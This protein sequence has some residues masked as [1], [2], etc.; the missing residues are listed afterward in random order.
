MS[1]GQ[2]LASLSSLT[3]FKKTLAVAVAVG[4]ATA[5]S[6]LWAE[7]DLQGRLTSAS[8]DIALSGAL[9]SIPELGRSTQTKRDGSF[10]FSQLPSGSYQ[11]QLNYLGGEKIE[12]KVDIRDDETTQ[13]KLSLKPADSELENILVIGNAAS[14]NTALN[15]QRSADSI[16][17][18]VKSDGIGQ[19]PDANTS[20]AL[21]RLPGISVEN[22]QGEGRFVRV[23]GL[24]P[25]FNS[26]TINGS[27]VPSPNAGNRAVA[28]DVIPSDIIESLEVYK[29]L[30]PDL[31]ADSLGGTVEV[32]SLS[33]FDRENG[34]YKLSV[35]NHYDS[36]TSQ[37]SPKFSLTGSHQL[38]LGSSDKNLGIAGSLSWFEREFGSDNVETGGAWSGDELGEFE[39]RDYQ[40]TRER[41]GFVLNF[42]FKASD[43]TQL[44][45]RT[46]STEYSDTEIRQAN[47]FE[48]SDDIASG[49]LAPAAQDEIV[50]GS[51]ELIQEEIEPSVIE[52]E[53][54]DRKETAKI[55]SLVLGG[56]TDLGLWKLDY[57]LG[58]SESS[59][60]TP[61]YID[62]AVFVRE[63]D[64]GLGFEGSKIIHPLAPEG[65]LQASEYGDFEVEL[66]EQITRDKEQNFKFNAERLFQMGKR[67]AS[68]KFGFKLSQREKDSDETVWAM[69]DEDLSLADFSDANANV[70][71]EFGEMGPVILSQQILDW[72]N[73]QNFADAR[74]DIDSI[75]NDFVINEDINASYLMGT[76]TVDKW[77][78][79]Y[80]LRYEATSTEAR[81]H[82]VRVVEVDDEEQEIF[83]L[84]QIDNDYSHLLPS[85]HLR[86]QLDDKTQLRAAITH[87]VV[88]PSF[89]QISPY[90]SQDGDEA[91]FGNPELEPL[92]SRNFDLGIEHYRGYAS[93]YSAFVFYKQIEDFI[94][95]IDLGENAG[96]EGV[97][98]A[99]T[100]RN[101]DT[102]TIKGLE[103]A[104]SQHFSDL[105]A[106][107]NGLFVS[108][109]ATWS[110]SEAQLGYYDDEVLLSRSL[111]MPSQ[112]DL[113]ANFAIGWESDR[114]SVRLAT[115][116]KSEYLLEVQSPDA[117]EEDI[118]VDEQQSVD[119]LGRWYVNEKLQVFI[120]G[121][122][123]SDEPYYTYVNRKRFNAQYEDYGPSYRLG[124]SLSH[125]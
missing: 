92:S 27:K 47:V 69:D 56:E 109:N 51:G 62:G 42:D 2:A 20:E 87:S 84:T 81:G 41:L 65:Y 53:L 66:A 117:A 101:G 19:Y 76:Y 38:A 95:G 4:A 93:A 58:S 97:E 82:S 52:R 10:S 5:S 120:Q 105:P 80:G 116:Y 123:L 83:A 23:R 102:A 6:Q 29:T 7:G 16:L 99:F 104:G 118:Y 33:A 55:S 1:T 21:Q 36:K 103:L 112:S 15:Q 30:T 90:Y 46:L 124:F 122:N 28:L 79:I 35:E 115:N 86:Y 14:I 60:D 9:V 13:I 85:F 26:V 54:K 3:F 31:D 89:E 67:S 108:A 43:N 24:G 107:W 98:E 18:V 8:G 113:S 70:D 77:K 78:F 12:Q 37:S 44:Y 91:E 73:M 48:F 39:Q 57:A 110:E 59:E 40:I 68:L 71:Y 22:D 63:F 96:I 114:F 88:R 50:D 11:L 74:E 119:L 121:I 94:Y 100:Y 32:K 45:L 64:Q 17:S 125:F 106:P 49:E 111:P 25:E 75:V 34:F 61:F 72:V